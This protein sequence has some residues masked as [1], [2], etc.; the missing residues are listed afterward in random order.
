M[1]WNKIEVNW[2]QFKANVKR[3]W[4]KLTDDQLELI[5][6]NRGQLV[7]K[8]QELYGISQNEAEKQL[9]DWQRLQKDEA[10][11]RNNRFDFNRHMEGSNKNMLDTSEYVS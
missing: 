1:N 3:Q 9:F 6:G 8:I 11:S 5:A 2:K 7:G 4:D 10:G